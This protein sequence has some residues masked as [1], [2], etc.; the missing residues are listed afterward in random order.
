[1]SMSWFQIAGS[2][3]IS[4]G[5]ATAA[6]AAAPAEYVIS[7]SVD[8]MGSSYMQGLID[9]NQLPSMKRIQSEGAGTNNARN[10]FDYTITLP[11]HTTMVTSRAVIGTAGDGPKVTSHNWTGN[12]D[13]A[14]GQTLATNKGAYIASVFDVVHDHGLRTGMWASKSKFSLFVTSY[15][16]VNGQPDVSGADNGKNK[17]DLSFISGNT[18]EMTT[19][20]ITAM[21][22]DT[23]RVNYAFVHYTDPDGAG[24]GQGWGGDAYNAALIKVD[25]QIGRILD[26]I[27]QTPALKGKTAIILTSDHGGTGHDHS[28]NK[29]ALDYTIP[30]YVWGAGV[31]HGD[32]Y[33]MNPA[34]RLAPGTSL[35]QSD[36]ASLDRPDYEPAVQPV[37]NGDLGNLSLQ[38]LG[39]PA[40]PGSS[41]NTRQDLKVST[42]QP[43]TRPAAADVG[44]GA[45]EIIALPD[46]Q[47]YVEKDTPNLLDAQTQWI[48][49]NK[50]AENIVF[51]THEG[52][53]VEEG[54]IAIQW[55]RANT[56]ISKLDGIVPYGIAWGNHDQ[57]AKG[58]ANCVSYFGVSSSHFA[59]KA[60]YGGASPD[61]MNS[62]QTFS[63]GGFSF[64]NLAI[65][66][67]GIDDA[68]T[69]AWAK[70]VLSGNPNKLVILTTHDY[71][72]PNGKDSQLSGDDG[73]LIYHNLVKPYANVIMTLNG[74]NPAERQHVDTNAAGGKVISMLADY[75]NMVNG[76]DGYLRKIRFDPKAG[77]IDVSTYSPTSATANLTG[78]GSQFSY[79]A[80]FDAATNSIAVTGLQE[81]VAAKPAV[82]APAQTSDAVGTR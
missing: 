27:D 8:G 50:A 9:S 36:G 67:D 53:M 30:F 66:K 51:V 59:G 77:R 2:V 47:H 37:R 82:V 39:L 79:T 49:N 57:K 23:T 15:D 56:A 41:L 58:A 4:A 81:P 32:L 44:A 17:V 64:I 75:Q 61:G 35:V 6:V 69:V 3:V 78:A 73:Q 74:H 60:W 7:I 80:T 13:P 52:D 34:T 70:D 29:L 11:N 54:G 55:D 38:L 18:A 5:L 1:M 62:Y 14:A 12:G 24:H 48:V 71:V 19:N 46:T 72:V 28:N 26:V 31:M 10:D 25:G 65:R 68:A 40:I 63:A 33:A 20:F 42:T 76:G 16:A 21:A 22:D 43:A 45:F